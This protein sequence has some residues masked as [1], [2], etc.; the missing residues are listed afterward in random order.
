MAHFLLAPSAGDGGPARTDGRAQLS[1][2]TYDGDDEYSKEGKDS[3]RFSTLAQNS[4]KRPAFNFK[5]IVSK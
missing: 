3:K 4:Q 2:K 5:Y 1:R